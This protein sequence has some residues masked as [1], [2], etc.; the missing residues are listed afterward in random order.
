MIGQKTLYSFFSPSPARKRRAGS[1]EPA[2][3]ETGVAAV[4]EE[5]GDAAANPPKKARVG[6]EEPGIPPSSPL[7]PE[8]L[9]RIQ[10]NKAAAL[11]RLAARNVPVGFG[12]SWKKHLSGEFGKPYFIKLMGFVA[13]ERRHYTVY[14][15]PEQVFTWTQMCDIRDVKVVILGQ[16]PYH[17]PN[18][19]HG[20]C[21]SVQRPIPPPPSLENIY[22][23]LST[24]IDGFVHPGHG[25]LSG[26]AKQGVLLLNAVLTVRAHQANSHKEK[27]WEQFTDA[28]VSWL[29]QNSNG[30]VFLLWGSY[31]Q[32]KGIAIDRKR[33]HVLQTAHPSPLSVY[34]GFFG[35]RH[36]S[37]TN[38][39]LQKSGKQPIN[40]KDL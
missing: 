27:G 10:K 6:Q 20:L 12:E 15:P 2:D 36:F 3:P 31:A 26:W 40:W 33:H 18:Q 30:L 38:E 21:F 35:C 28:V 7:S 4:A 5:S 1:P 11:L 34:R 23:E 39:L 16:D 13:E 14:P 8:Q 24:D 17:G 37:K 32:K 22:K 25:D 19:A 9:V 29:N